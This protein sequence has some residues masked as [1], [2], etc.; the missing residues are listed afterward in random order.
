MVTFPAC[1][2]GEFQCVNQQC[3]PDSV[4][5]DGKADCFDRTDEDKCDSPCPEGRKGCSVGGQCVTVA[6][7]CDHK[8]DCPDGSD[9]ASCEYPQ[10][11][12]SEFRCHSGQCVDKDVVCYDGRGAKGSGCYDQ[13]HLMN[14]S[15][16]Q[17]REGEFKCRRSYCI[18]GDQQCDG[19]MDCEMTYTDEQGG[20]P[21][22]C[23][24]HYQDPVCT[25]QQEKMNCEHKNLTLLP[26]F[27]VKMEPYSQFHL[28]GNRLQLNANTFDELS[29]MTI[30]DLSNNSLEDIPDGIFINQW[31]LVSLNLQNNGI[32]EL[33]NGT[34]KGLSNLKTL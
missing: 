19:N 10:C 1:A 18:D 8:R 34:F 3:V 5:C 27:N 16:H 22:S 7:W 17:C 11:A 31:R 4:R 2:Q 26:Y 20:C 25:C 30:L 24:Y 21:Y 6:Q 29:R 23:P 15:A 33:S 32:T 28:S 14:C 9:E 12:S 13:S